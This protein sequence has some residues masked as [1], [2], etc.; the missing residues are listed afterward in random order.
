MLQMFD[1]LVDFHC[2]HCATSLRWR[3]LKFTS[4]GNARICPACEALVVG[5]LHPAVFNNWLWSRFY[6]PGVLLCAVGIFVPSL[7]WLLPFA[8]VVLFAGFAVIVIYMIKQ[9]IGWQ[10]YRPYEPKRDYKP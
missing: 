7:A 1:P 10:V 5:N 8:V 2:P 9:R 6:L 3:L 4:D